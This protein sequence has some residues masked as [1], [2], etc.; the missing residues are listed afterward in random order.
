MT[1]GGSPALPV[2]AEVAARAFPGGPPMSR[3]VVFCGEHLMVA[4]TRLAPG[5]AW[6]TTRH[7]EEEVVYV[8]RGRLQYD[9]GRLVTEGMVTVNPS[10][11]D[12]PGRAAGPDPALLLEIYAPPVE[13]LRPPR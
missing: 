11:H 4:V 3:H 7:P 1:D 10:L 12:H 5:A 13:A 6:T 8:V 9:D 2:V